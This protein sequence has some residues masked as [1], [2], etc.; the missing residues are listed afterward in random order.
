MIW[1]MYRP[2]VVPGTDNVMSLAMLKVATRTVIKRLRMEKT[3]TFDKQAELQF[4][5]ANVD[6]FDFNA[7][8]AHAA[9][10]GRPLYTIVCT[11]MMVMVMTGN[12]HVRALEIEHQI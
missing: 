6:E 11:I 5:L 3:V 9:T 4:I 2:A 1:L 10:D 12:V 7:I 8:K